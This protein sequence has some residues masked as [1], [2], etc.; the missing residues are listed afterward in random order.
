MLNETFGDTAQFESLNLTFTTV[1]NLPDTIAGNAGR[2][3]ATSIYF[4]IRLNANILPDYSQE[5]I[6]ST[7]YHEILHTYMYSKL[8]DTI[9]LTV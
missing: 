9:P 8:T 2:A 1:T 5:Y 4:D 6:L 3:S 7:I